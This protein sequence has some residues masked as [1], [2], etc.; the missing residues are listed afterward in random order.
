MRTKQDLTP[1]EKAAIA[2]QVTGFSLGFSQAQE[3]Y[4][5]EAE[6][7]EDLLL[8]QNIEKCPGCEWWVDSHELVGPDSDEPDG[9]CRNC[10]PD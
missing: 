6:V 2:D 7:L 1:E 9:H 4:E 10:R 8:D 3:Q 5:L